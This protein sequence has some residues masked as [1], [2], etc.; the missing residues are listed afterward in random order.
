MFSELELALL[1]DHT[2]IMQKFRAVTI[3]DTA[4]C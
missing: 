1:K 4:D 2:E 3:S